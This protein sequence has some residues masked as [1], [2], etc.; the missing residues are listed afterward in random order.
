MSHFQNTNRVVLPVST[1][2]KSAVDVAIQAVMEAG[3]TLLAHFRHA[4]T[5]RWK[6]KS[7]VTTDTDVLSEKQ[8]V[9]LLVREFPTHGILAEES[10]RAGTESDYCWTVDP[11]DGTNNFLFELTFFCCTVALTRGDDVLACATY[12]PIHKELFCAEQGKGAFLN[13]S[14]IRVSDREALSK[15]LVAAD[16]GYD[17]E[18]G[19]RTIDTSKDLWRQVHSLRILGSAALALAYVA[20]GRIDLYLHRCLF[21][22]DI[23][24]GI[25]LVREA[26][27]RVTD[28]EGSPATPHSRQISAGNPAVQQE[29]IRLNSGR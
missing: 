10:G 12:D 23:A 17:P 5:V 20:C 1:S 28:W 13:G 9:Q 8:I 6:G 19:S 11:L 21:P 18:D 7:N 4:R 2:G 14:R 26:S 27:G 16:L 25:L 15:C 3:S 24:G 22:W 29:F